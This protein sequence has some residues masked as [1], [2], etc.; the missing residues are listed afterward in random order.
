MLKTILITGSNGFVARNLI[1]RLHEK[2]YKVIEFNRSNTTDELS[3]FINE[4]HIIVHLAGVNRPKKLNEFNEV[5]IN[6]TKLLLDLV[7]KN[8]K[9]IPII[10]ASSIQAKLNNPYGWS[11]LEAEKIFKKFSLN[12][13][14]PIFIFR[15]PN[16]FGKWCKP[17]YNSVVATFCYNIINNKKI[18]INDPKKVLKLIHI[19]DVIDQLVEAFKSKNKGFHLEEMTKVHEISLENLLKYLKEFKKSRSNLTIDNVGDGFLRLLYSTFLSYLQ[20]HQFDYPLQSHKDQRGIFMEIL[21]TKS[22]G[23]FS[24]FSIRPGEIRGR[25]Y[26]HIK[27]EKFLILKGK[28]LFE[29]Q[30]IDTKEKYKLLISE[31]DKRV[32]ETIPGW[33]HTIINKS[34]KFEAILIV[35]ANEVFNKKIPD[36]FKL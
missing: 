1:F 28:V 2:K 31:K 20:P 11:K 16:I 14:H 10:F 8:K 6:L 36:T 4:S 34:K 18:K 33:M 15:L 5:N 23:Q 27:N 7:K 22:S 9:K 19:D 3:K 30:H 17:N 12:E 29:F 26:H 25:H 24:Y 32:V 13:N 35:W 21:K